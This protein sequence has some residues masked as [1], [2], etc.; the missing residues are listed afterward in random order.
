M[1]IQFLSRLVMTT[2]GALVGAAS[3]IVFYIPADIA[4]AGVTGL[5]VILNLLFGT[6]VGMVTLLF[7]IPILYLGYRMLGGWSNLMW[8]IYVVVV[9][10]LSLDVLT[11]LFPQAGI[12][13]DMTFN[14]IFAGVVGGI[15][16]G[17]IYRAGAAF[18][19]TSTIARILQE[20]LGTPLST[21]YLYANLLIVGLAGIF[22]GWESALLALVALTLEGAASDYMMEGPSIIRTVTII[23]NHPQEVSDAVLHQLR[24]GVTGWQGQGMYTGETRH[25]LF[26]TIPR[27]QVNALRALVFETDPTAF[28][29]VGHGHVAYGGEFKRAIPRKNGVKLK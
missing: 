26:V 2:V 21:T 24:R 16:S 6:P 22:I 19:G 15:S 4:P 29:I 11:P 9:Y 5:S 12:S 17:L 18:G 20:K 1:Q 13:Q 27:S 25:I 3:V 7:N 14:A 8:T 10:S 23:T 28:L